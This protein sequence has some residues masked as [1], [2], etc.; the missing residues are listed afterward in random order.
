MRFLAQHE[1]CRVLA[2]NNRGNIYRD[3]KDY[4]KALS[5]Y[6]QA[7]RLEPNFA[8]V[9]RNRG[10]MFKEQGRKQ[11]ADADFAK[12]AQLGRSEAGNL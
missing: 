10:K 5:D 7:I 11:E 6:N 3:E 8:L 9:Y 4:N 12:A 2:Y 1:S